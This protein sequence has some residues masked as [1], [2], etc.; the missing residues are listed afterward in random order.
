[1]SLKVW[2]RMGAQTEVSAGIQLH[3]SSKFLQPNLEL[4]HACQHYL[5]GV[6]S[7]EHLLYSHTK[8]TELSM[9][10]VR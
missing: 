1:M 3:E 6:S 8:A 4:G 9:S 5:E 7:E 10:K 2:I